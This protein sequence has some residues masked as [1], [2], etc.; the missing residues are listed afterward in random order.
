MDVKKI[1]KFDLLL[2]EANEIDKTRTTSP[3]GYE[4][5]D[6]DRF[7]EWDVKVENFLFSIFDEHSPIFKAYHTR[8]QNTRYGNAFKLDAIK[9]V[10]SAAK[11]EYEDGAVSTTITS[12]DRVFIGHGRSPLWRELKDYIHDN[13]HLP[14]DEFNRTPVAGLSTV[15]RLSEMMSN[16]A[17]AFLVMTAEDEQAN[18]TSNARMNVIH[19]VGLFQGKLGFEKAIILLEEGGAEFTNINGLGQLRFPK[20]NISAIFHLIRD[21]LEREGLIK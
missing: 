8:K 20:G 1:K 9:S 13:L 5:V 7:I 18:G 15:T 14:W 11:S 4:Y 3:S 12:G 16:A 19:E 17:I 10:L 6:S 21:V 2:N